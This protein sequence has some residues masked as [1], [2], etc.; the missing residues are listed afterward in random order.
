[1]P[2]EWDVQPGIATPGNETPG[3][4]PGG[5]IEEF[6]LVLDA[7]LGIPPTGETIQSSSGLVLDD[8]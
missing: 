1:M 8:F 5:E 4:P 6:G 7:F 3:G 2:N